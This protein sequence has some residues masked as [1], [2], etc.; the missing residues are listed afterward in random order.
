[1]N[2]PT[3]D[4]IKKL[5]EEQRQLKEEVRQLREQITEPIPA[6]TRIEVASAD[7]LNQLQ[8]ISQ[9]QD[10]Q[11]TYIKKEFVSVEERQKRQD[12]ALFTHSKH[13]SE[14]H[15]EMK[16]LATKQ[17]LATLKTAQDAHF[18]QLEATRDEHNRK[19]DEQHDM[20]RQILRLLGQKE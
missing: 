4:R 10:Q 17:D 6:T 3:E 19:L 12:E 15:E 2:Q 1:M 7:V 18:D 5:E 11:F 16:G 13:I 8:A 9:E 14:L 20:L